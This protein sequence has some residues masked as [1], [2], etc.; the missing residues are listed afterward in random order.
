MTDLGYVTCITCGKSGH[1]ADKAQWHPFHHP[2]KV[3]RDQEVPNIFKR[4]RPS[5]ERQNGAE[6]Q[7]SVV[8]SSMPFDPVLRQALITKGVLTPDD[9]REAEKAIFAIT[10]MMTQGVQDVPSTEQR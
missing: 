8:Q 7:V 2:L 4:D 1:P 6:T 3:E 9:L 5:S 10:G